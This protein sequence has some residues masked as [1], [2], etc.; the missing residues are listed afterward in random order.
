M[1]VT[2]QATPGLA[3]TDC[4]RQ[5]TKTRSAEGLGG[6]RPSSLGLALPIRIWGPG[7]SPAGAQ[8]RTK[9]TNQPATYRAV[10]P[11]Q[12]PAGAQR[13][14]KA[15]KH[16]ATDRAVHETPRTKATHEPGRYRD[17]QV[18]RPVSLVSRSDAFG[19]ACARLSP[20]CDESGGQ[21]DCQLHAAGGRAVAGV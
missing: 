8:R 15:T 21:R 5:E 18:P 4:P 1:S 10:H 7:Q 19:A 12:S 17:V 20:V 3:G 11:V 2:N 14:T 9:A 16:P 13:R 6:P